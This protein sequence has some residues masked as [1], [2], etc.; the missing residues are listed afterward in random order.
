[1]GTGFS[2]LT[3]RGGLGNCRK[4]CVCAVPAWLGGPQW[5]EDPPGEVSRAGAWT[6]MAMLLC[7]PSML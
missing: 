4:E 7:L 5:A 6:E 3:Q 2:S 1:M